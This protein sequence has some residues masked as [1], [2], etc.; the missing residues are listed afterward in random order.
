MA[1]LQATPTA[2]ARLEAF[3]R[4]FGA[5]PLSVRAWYEVVDTV[6]FVGSCRSWEH[7]LGQLAANSM[8]D[9]F[10]KDIHGSSRHPLAL[11]APLAVY[12]LEVLRNAADA[13]HAQTY[14]LPL[15][16]DS[17]SLYAEIPQPSPRSFDF[18]AHSADAVLQSNLASTTF[19]EYLRGCFQFGGF[20]G[21]KTIDTRPGQEI[22]ALTADL[23]PL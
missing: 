7:M 23:L 17:E 3:E 6:N 10:E 1:T 11:L 14:R 20:P 22:A 5:L 16:P 8:Q 15:L 18:P 12:R 21:W 9:D 19:V 13:T 4:Q 2:L